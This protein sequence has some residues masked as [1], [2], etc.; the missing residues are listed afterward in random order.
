MLS[1][2]IVIYS[3]ASV[4]EASFVHGGLFSTP[5][6]VAYTV[7][8]SLVD[9][10][11]F[12]SPSFAKDE[13]PRTVN[14]FQFNCWAKTGSVP[15][16]KVQLMTLLDLVEHSRH[17]TDHQTVVVH[18]QYDLCCFLSAI[19]LLLFYRAAAMQLWYCDEQ[20]SV[21][22]SVKCVNCDKTNAASEKSSIMTNRKSP[23]SF[24]VSLRWTAYVALTPKRGPQ[25]RF[26]F[27]F[28]IKNW[29][30]LEESLLQSFFVWKLSAAQLSVIHW[31][32]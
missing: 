13:G 32:I 16:S 30:L 26:F 9:V 22:L 5:S 12:Q 20:L 6:T 21:P 28:R 25:K 27:I 1:L 3:A 29:A 14:H 4:W 18:C 10:G 19:C 23:M 2:F 31:P 15:T 8:R 24:P 11:W 17:K 7:E